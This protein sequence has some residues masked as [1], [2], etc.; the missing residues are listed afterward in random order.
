MYDRVEKSVE[1]IKASDWKVYQ[2]GRGGLPTTQL[3]GWMSDDIYLGLVRGSSGD[4]PLDRDF[5]EDP[6]LDH[7]SR[8]DPP[9]DRHFRGDPP[10]EHA[11]IMNQWS[12]RIMEHPQ[13]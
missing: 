10:L 5:R 9:L 6:P 3:Y 13:Y 12:D 1:D 8:G 4:P 2:E 7:N 11:S